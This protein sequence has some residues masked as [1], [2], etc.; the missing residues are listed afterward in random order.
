MKTSRDS[1]NK[2]ASVKGSLM[3]L[4]AALLALNGNGKKYDGVSLV[5]GVK[6]NDIL[7]F[8]ERR[9]IKPTQLKVFP[10]RR[11]GT[12]SAKINIP[13]SIC[14]NILNK[15]FWPQFVFCKPWVSKAKMEK[16]IRNR[17]A[18]LSQPR[19]YSTLV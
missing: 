9:N 12:L 17:K 15:D 5:E 4:K 16:E 10:S 11:K 7:S 2:K 19:G 1:E 8:L 6:A 18:Q 14:S 3:Q 13:S